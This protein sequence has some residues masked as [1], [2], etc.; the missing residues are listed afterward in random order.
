[1]RR[2]V[3][4]ALLLM[5]C[6][7]VVV[8]AAL[9]RGCSRSMRGSSP[10]E[11]ASKL[12]VR[13]F[14]AE[15]GK[16]EAI[17]L[18]DYL[19]GVVAAEMPAEFETEALKAQMVVARTYTVRRMRA[20][21]FTGG[22]PLN[23]DADVCAGPQSGQAYLRPEEV[24]E[25]YGV[26]TAFRYLE[27][28]RAAEEETRG[29]ILTH[30]GMPIEALYHASSGNRTEDPADYYGKGYAYLQPVP[31]PGGQTDPRYEVTVTFTPK[32]LSQ[33]LGVTV[34]STSNAIT[35]TERTASGRAKTVRIGAATVSGRELR[36]KLGLRS[37][38]FRIVVKPGQIEV[39]TRGYGH[40]IGMSQYGANA[41][42]K[43]GKDWRAIVGHYYTGVRV[44][45][46]FSE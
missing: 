20:F 35:I 21:N 40:G 22:C 45:R 13:V 41:F 8:P 39:T 38:D 32:V 24:R 3:N 25:K 18:A 2:V 4:T 17:P 44:D 28:L 12:P 10:D 46:I 27:R 34:P 15:T 1:M 36:E 7:L 9:G 31:D 37:T 6:M 26:L 29:L 30:M 16:I 14:F 23:A 33:K 42:A 5:L 19:I 43:A 11:G